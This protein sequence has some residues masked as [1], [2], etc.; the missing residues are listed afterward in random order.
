MANTTELTTLTS[1]STALL[2]NS[3]LIEIDGALRRISLDNLAKVINQ[4]GYYLRQVAW[5]VPLMQGYDTLSWGVIGNTLM[6][7]EWKSNS[8]RY[9]LTNSGD[10]AK[11]SKT[12]STVYADGTALDESK[13][14]IMW[15]APRIYYLVQN[16]SGIPILW[17]SQLPIS[18]HYIGTCNGGLHNCYG[19]YKAS[20]TSDGALTSRSGVLRTYSKTL[21]QFWNYAR[22]NGKD[23]GLRDYAFQQLIV[24]LGLSE[25][26]NPDIQSC[27]GR[28]VTGNSG[29][30]INTSKWY[31]GATAELG[32]A[33]GKIDITDATTNSC[34][35]SMG[36]I[37][38]PYGLQWEFAQG[39]YGIG[40][41]F[42]IYTGNRLLSS[43]ER[44]NGPTG[45]YRA[46]SRATTWSSSYITELHLGEYFDVAPKTASGG[47]AS[48]PWC[49]AC[50]SAN[51][52]GGNV[53][54]F[55][56]SSNNGSYCGLVAPDSTHAWTFSHTSYGSRLA[57]YGTLNF[58]NGKDI[59]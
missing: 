22:V 54:L 17:M 36:G 45:D 18:G 3:V 58:V 53:V 20:V 52:D 16:E 28:G 35:V 13:G 57:Y 24:M 30:S 40:S 31:N 29:I 38:D 2:T 11:L 14:H 32:D 8:G 26:G 7:E 25:Y 15:I 50:W 34:R 39:I 33:W 23:F 43:D 46:L 5:G 6:Y 12:D 4:Y 21:E 19:A 41:Y 49:D 59:A 27:L 48:T 51:T 56:G 47:S 55:G 9:L 1:V 37:E 10:A 42:Y 44:T